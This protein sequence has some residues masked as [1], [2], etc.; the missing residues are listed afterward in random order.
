MIEEQEDTLQLLYKSRECAEIAYSRLTAGASYGTVV[1]GELELEDPD[2]DLE[3]WEVEE[4]DMAQ[5]LSYII[6]D[7]NELIDNLEER[8]I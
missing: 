8:E 1:E 6:F 2:S 3:E 4:N 5:K 7:L